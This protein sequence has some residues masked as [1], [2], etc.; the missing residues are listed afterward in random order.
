MQQLSLFNEVRNLWGEVMFVGASFG[1]CVDWVIDN[2]DL[3][4]LEMTEDGAEAALYEFK[5][6][7]EYEIVGA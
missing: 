2:V 6:L 1:A 3:W 5:G 4:E 7:Q